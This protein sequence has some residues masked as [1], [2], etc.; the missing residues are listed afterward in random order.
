MRVSSLVVQFKGVEGFAGEGI[1][2]RWWRVLFVGLELLI[3]RGWLWLVLEWWVV[4]GVLFELALDEE[5]AVV[6]FEEG[7]C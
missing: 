7:G 4:G 5:D 1:V 2:E 3:L 6:F